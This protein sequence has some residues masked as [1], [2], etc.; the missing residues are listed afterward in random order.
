MKGE[1]DISA[2]T[3]DRRG[4]LQSSATSRQGGVYDPWA[5]THDLFALS[6]L[7][8]KQSIVS[9]MVSPAS[10]FPPLCIFS[11][12]P[13]LFKDSFLSFFAFLSFL[14]FSDYYCFSFFVNS[15]ISFSY[16]FDVVFKSYVPRK[17]TK[18]HSF[19]T[20]LFH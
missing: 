2:V 16:F 4:H 8:T 9:P 1:R 3:I 18:S 20:R 7:K 17:F 14:C 15:H 6:F 19:L 12:F 11:F 5:T 13:I 10:R